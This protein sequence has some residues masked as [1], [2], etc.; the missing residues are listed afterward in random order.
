MRKAKIVIGAGW[1]DEGK[2][3][4]TDHY[5]TNDTL[6]VRF[7]G[8]AQAGHTVCTPEGRRH[9]F[10]HVG[11]GTFRGAATYLSR[12]FICNP[13]LLN[14]EMGALSMLGEKPR[15]YVDPR[16]LLT[17][18]YDMIVN[19]MAEE[20]RGDKRHGSCGLGINETMLRSGSQF[21]RLTAGSVPSMTWLDHIRSPWLPERLVKLGVIAKSEWVNRISSDELMER[22]FH[23]WQ[24]FHNHVTVAQSMPTSWRGPILFEGAQG[25][26]LDQGHKFFPHVTHSYTGLTNVDILAKEWMIDQLDVTH[27]TRA[28]ATRHGAGPFPH[29][30]PNLK[31]YDDTNAP[32]EWQGALRFAPLD[33]DLLAE[34]IMVDLGRTKI[35]VKHQLAVTHVDQTPEI[36]F[37][38]YGHIRQCSDTGFTDFLDTK[39]IQMSYGPTRK[40]VLSM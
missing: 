5:A 6:V 3:L 38:H 28:Y 15:V 35:P 25:L 10:H 14:E 18:P 23:Q 30:D 36:V 11:S 16:A 20:A 2:G 24:V 21:F 12:F 40:D 4:I 13:I 17:T 9:V 32:G 39:D 34:S 27:V 37:I 33:L 29:E 26:L 31:Y 8:G 7:N 19:Q 22:F 1:G